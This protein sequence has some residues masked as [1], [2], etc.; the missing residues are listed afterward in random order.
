M[1]TLVLFAACEKAIISERD[2]SLTLVALLDTVR[3]TVPEGIEVPPDV[4][5]SNRWDIVTVWRAMEEDA[6]S[7][8][9]QRTALIL[10]DDTETVATILPMNIQSTAHRNVINVAGFP[11]AQEGKCI[12]R[13]WLREQ[14]IEDW[15]QPTAEYPLTVAHETVPSATDADGV[16]SDC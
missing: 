12:L 1:I 16:R 6:G 10:P 2:N 4:S 7:Q 3:I 8:Y 11:V 15:G 13:L 9:E 5:A 14:G